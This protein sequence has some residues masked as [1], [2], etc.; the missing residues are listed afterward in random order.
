M[1]RTRLSDLPAEVQDR[2]K[3]M[4]PADLDLL[5][6]EVRGL[7]IDEEVTRH[8]ADAEG[9]AKGARAALCAPAALAVDDPLVAFAAYRR[10][11]ATPE[12]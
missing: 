9:A 6:T 4:T 11:R 10:Q 12:K 8:P 7:Q 3:A 5:A 2:L 1:D